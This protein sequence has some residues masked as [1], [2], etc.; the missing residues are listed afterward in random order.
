[1]KKY[2]QYINRFL[3]GISLFSLAACND[4]LDEEPLS[5]IAP[6][7]YLQTE[8]QLK[9]YVDNYYANYDR[10]DGNSDDKGGM[11]PSHYDSSSPYYDDNAT[12]NQ[13]GLMAV[14]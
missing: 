11:L 4:F 6:E 9:A 14:I 1:M 2:T 3:L 13:Y 5:D 12:D 7:Q 10:Y 8:E